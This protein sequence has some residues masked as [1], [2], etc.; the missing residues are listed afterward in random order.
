MTIRI[1][2]LRGA[3]QGFNHVGDNSMT[4]N[5]NALADRVEAAS[6]PDRELDALIAIQVA[7][8]W[9]G[10]AEGDIAVEES[11]RKFGVEYVVDRVANSHKSIWKLLPRY[12]ASLDAAMTLVPEGWDWALYTGADGRCEAGCAPADTDPEGCRTADSDQSL[13]ATPALALTAAALRAR[14]VTA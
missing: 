8:R 14:A 2:D 9:E 5:L 3:G 12:T 1:N 13:A 10:W 7:W 4:E 6:G 11:A